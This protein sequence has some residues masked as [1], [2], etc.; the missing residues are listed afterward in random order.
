MWRQYF[1]MINCQFPQCVSLRCG[2]CCLNSTCP[3]ALLIDRFLACHNR[4]ID[5]VCQGAVSNVFQLM[6]LR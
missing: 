5:T 4:L 1:L 3:F 6:I 2:A